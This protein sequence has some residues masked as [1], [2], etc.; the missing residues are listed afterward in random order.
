[1][2]CTVQFTV[3]GIKRKKKQKKKKLKASAFSPWTAY[4]IKR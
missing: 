2:D 4:N 3:K 1:V